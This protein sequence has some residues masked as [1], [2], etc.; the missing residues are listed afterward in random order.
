MGMKLGYL[1]VFYKQK[2]QKNI[3]GVHFET[4]QYIF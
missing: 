2:A 3:T 4:I 1:S